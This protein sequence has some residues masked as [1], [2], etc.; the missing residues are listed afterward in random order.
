MQARHFGFWPR[1]LPRRL[2][3]AETTLHARLAAAARRSPDKTLTVF[4]GAALSYAQAHEAVE[5]LAGF[6]QQDCAVV[7]G[8]R[9]LIDLQSSPQ[10]LIALYAALRADAMPVP[11]SPMC[12]E[13]ELAGYVEDC[14]ARV[15]IVGQESW[16][17]LEPLVGRTPLARVVVAAYRDAI[18]P[19]N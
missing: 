8:E 10:F 6:L 11:V 17:Q 7:P 14:T 4:F 19:D 15:A 13:R 12:V 5:R 3:R 9:V 1:D 2:P 16:P 18:S